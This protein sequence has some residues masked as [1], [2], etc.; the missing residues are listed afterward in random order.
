MLIIFTLTFFFA[1]LYS[2]ST[3]IGVLTRSPIVSI[4]VTL[5]V[6]FGLWM[7]GAF[8]QTLVAFDKDPAFKSFRDEI[9]NWIYSTVDTVHFVL[10]RTSDLDVLN[11]H[12]VGTVLTDQQRREKG[13]YS[14]PDVNWPESVIV[15]LVFI[16][17]MLGLACWRFSR[18]DY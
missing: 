6:W 12:L 10:P 1:I 9:P 11:M 14:L 2:V 7:A 17:I 13:F 5:V 18:K 4:L 8:H 15:S 3:L 16:A